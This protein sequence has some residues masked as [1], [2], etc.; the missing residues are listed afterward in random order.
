MPELPEVETVR[1]RL[2]PSVVGRTIA[3][4]QTSKPS[5]FFLTPPSRLQKDLRGLTVQALER[6]GKY[7]VATFDTGAR[8]LMHLGMTGQ[9]RVEA[10]ATQHKRLEPH[11]H[12]RLSFID[13]GECVYFRDV[14]KF[15]K[16]RLLAPG[17]RE[18]RLDKL[19]PDALQTPAETLSQH[20]WERTRKRRT[21][22]KS[23]LLDQSLLAGVGNIYADE[24]LFA[25]RVRPTRQAQRLRKLD[26]VN[27]T[28]ALQRILQRSVEIGGS[29]IR[30]YVSADG[31]TGR[32]QLEHLVYGRE[33]HACAVC[34]QAIA[35]IVLSARSTH[36]CPNCQR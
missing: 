25:A 26:T 11:V 13:G 20:L 10:P 15:G 8:L 22:V 33:G 29:T 23:L 21:P 30:D 32:A 17:D 27:L 18:K 19:G 24:A 5:Y 1:R 9:L 7:L 3:D 36:F 16:V 12:L 35:R 14:R 4:V 31:E 6:H 2:E 34:D 28:H